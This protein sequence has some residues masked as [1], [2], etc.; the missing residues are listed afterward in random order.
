MTLKTTLI[1]VKELAAFAPADVLIV[2]TEL[3]GAVDA[4]TRP[5]DTSLWRVLEAEVLG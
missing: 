2:A 5:P 1:D 3:R 4:V